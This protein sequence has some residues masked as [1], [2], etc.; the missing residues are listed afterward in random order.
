M[1]IVA[2]LG[3]LVVWVT[4]VGTLLYL[5]DDLFCLGYGYYHGVRI[6]LCFYVY[7]ALSTNEIHNYQGLRG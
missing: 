7:T 4:S 2:I 3:S 1:E 6:Q 5:V